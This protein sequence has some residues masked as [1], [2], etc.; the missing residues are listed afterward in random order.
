MLGR[1]ATVAHHAGPGFPKGSVPL[2][3]VRVLSRPVPAAVDEPSLWYPI[4]G[5][6]D[7]ARTKILNE[8][9]G[10]RDNARTGLYAISRNGPRTPGGRAGIRTLDPLIKSQLLCQLSYAPPRFLDIVN[11]LAAQCSLPVRRT[12]RGRVHEAIP[13]RPARRKMRVQRTRQ[14][15]GR[16]GRTTA[17]RRRATRRSPRPAIRSRTPR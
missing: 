1:P 15:S 6:P 7:T 4:R 10:N 12:A 5:T 14:G 11:A 8:S 2:S 3:I 13:A 9:A 17:A 16:E